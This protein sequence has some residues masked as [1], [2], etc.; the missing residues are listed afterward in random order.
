MYA[1]LIPTQSYSHSILLNSPLFPLGVLFVFVLC[2]ASPRFH[3]AR[4]LVAV[5]LFML[6]VG[7]TLV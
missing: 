3:L 5:A 6:Y 7:Q 1:H 4:L 2:I